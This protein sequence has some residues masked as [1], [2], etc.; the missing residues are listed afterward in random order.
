MEDDWIRAVEYQSEE[1]IKQQ[2]LIKQREDWETY[3]KNL[4]TPQPEMNFFGFETKRS[5][6]AAEAWNRNGTNALNQIKIHTDAINQINE[7]LSNPRLLKQVELYH[8]VTAH[9]ENVDAE[10]AR[11]QA[12]TEEAKEQRRLERLANA[13]ANVPAVD[14]WA[15]LDKVDQTTRQR[16]QSQLNGSG[17][18]L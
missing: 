16:S 13:A 2:E 5:K 6:Q 14:Y 10:N 1:R 11:I 15:Q 8:K 12:A 4:E 9:N 17:L 7:E 18:S 3:L